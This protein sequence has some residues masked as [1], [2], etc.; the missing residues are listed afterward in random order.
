MRN[1]VHY[2]VRG[3][4]VTVEVGV[5]CSLV[6]TNTGPEVPEEEIAGLFEP[7]R[8]LGSERLADAAGV[9]LGLSIVR[10]V[11]H[12]HQGEVRAEPGPDGGLRV[13]VRLP[14]IAG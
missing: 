5:D 3:G 13:E 2:N 6:V 7:F 10:S 14:P 4:S 9:G 1:G 11:T 12:A 8:R